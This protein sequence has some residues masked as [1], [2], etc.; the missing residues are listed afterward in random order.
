MLLD[1]SADVVQPDKMFRSVREEPMFSSTRLVCLITSLLILLSSQTLIAGAKT[2]AKKSSEAK[3]ARKSDSDKDDKKDSDKKESGDTDDDEEDDPEPKLSVT[4]HVITI[5]GKE[6]KYKATAGY[7]RLKDYQPKK[8]SGDSKDQKDKSSK[9][10]TDEHKS[11]AKVFFIAYTR[12][13]V[14]D[15]AKRPVSFSFNGGPGSSS[16]WLHMGGLGPRR[17]LLTDRGEALPP[18]YRLEDNAYSWLDLTDLVFIDPVSTGFSRTEADEDPKNFHGYK[19]DIESVAEFIRLYTTKNQRWPSPKLLVGESYG[20]TRAAGLSEFLQER[21]GI[22]LNGI[23]LVS[24][25]LNFATLDFAPNNDMPF[26]LYL[27]SYAATAWYHKKLSAD[28]Q[29]KPLS[30]VL[31]EAEAFASTDYLL[32]LFQGDRLS[33]D[34]IEQLSQRLSDFTSLPAKDIARLNARV[35]D[36]LFFTRLLMDKNRQVGR[37]DSRYTGIRYNPGTDRNDFDPSFEAVSGPFTATF[38]DYIRRE[39]HFESELPYETLANVWPWSFKS[40]ENRYVNVADD[41]R[42]AMTRNPYLKVWICSGY[43]DLATPYFA[44]KYTV[45]QMSLDPLIRKNI[46]L[47][48]YDAGHMMYVYKPALIKFKSDFETFLQDACLPD[49]RAVPS[50]DP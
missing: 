5:G 4:E 16:V 18:P 41:L 8:K 40:F 36:E 24:S 25:V 20:T 17:A 32:S 50:V 15:I 23:A 10:K 12:Q 39:L 44:S 42:R 6:I 38:N 11:R 45:D 19:E 37:F 30:S 26:V 47:T 3:D 31:E 29:S 43:Y 33:Q 28:M 27:P 22:Y 48:Y 35:P 1:S 14:G 13:D 34:K 9:S 49:S 7:M 2:P 21:Y 46:R